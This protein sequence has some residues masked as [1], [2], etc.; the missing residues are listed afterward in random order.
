MIADQIEGWNGVCH[1]RQPHGALRAKVSG[2]PSVPMRSIRILKAGFENPSLVRTLLEEF[3]QHRNYDRSFVRKLFEVARGQSGEPWEIRRLAVLIVEHQI[4]KLDRQDL[5]EHD[6][7]FL[8]LGLKAAAGLQ[9]R[10]N[11]S[12][13]KEGYSTTNLEAFVEQFMRK[14]Q[15]LNRVHAQIDAEN[16]STRALTAFLRLSRQD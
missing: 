4:L 16:T 9:H 15:R 11:E 13:L 3:L 6:F 2:L 5:S 1:V 10:I 8:Q 14:L 12:V 7:L